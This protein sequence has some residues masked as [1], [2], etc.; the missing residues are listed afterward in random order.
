MAT[1]TIQASEAARQ[2]GQLLDRASRGE[3]FLITRYGRPYAMITPPPPR[4]EGAD[5]P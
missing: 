5:G 3:T 1:T 4:S 2:I